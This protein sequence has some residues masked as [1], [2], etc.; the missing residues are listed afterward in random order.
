MI[1]P[2][3]IALIRFK[4][5]FF[6]TSNLTECISYRYP[7]GDFLHFTKNLKY[8]SF[9]IFKFTEAPFD[10]IGKHFLLWRE[11]KLYLVK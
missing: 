5:A 8:K 6:L 4:A 10:A 2:F 9:E 3:P 7:T 1:V 11:E